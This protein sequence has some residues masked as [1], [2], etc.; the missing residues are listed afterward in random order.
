LV[1]LV[2]GSLHVLITTDTLSGVWSYTRELVTGLVAEGIRVTLV[3][4]GEI[5]V[6]SQTKWMENLKGLEYRPTAFGLDWMQEAEQ[7]YKDSCTYLAALVKERNPDL[8]HF[9]H[10][11]Y[12]SLNVKT[13]RVVVAHGDLINWWKAVHG[14]EPKETQWLRRYCQRIS[15]GLVEADAIVAPSVWMM[16]SLR[17]TYIVSRSI[18]SLS[19]RSAVAYHGRNPVMFNPYG[20]KDGSALALGRA[21]DPA[22]Q[23][24]LLTQHNHSVP[25]SIVASA[26]STPMPHLPIRTDVKFADEKT[27]IS[28]KGQQTEDQMRALYSRSS[29]Y[30]A[31]ARYDPFGTAG[32]EAAL[33]RCAILANDTPLFREMW[34]ESAVFF[35]TNSASSLA[36][37][38]RRLSEDRELRRSYANRAFH[39]AHECFTSKR[40]VDQYVAL[41]DG[42]LTG[43]QAKA[44]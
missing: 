21:F 27:A 36:S 15:E 20:K 37:E 17:D 24:G 19:K 39:R 10:P 25:I 28:M 12:G 18:S 33:S 23:L 11:C 30:V 42:V 5:P 13:H 6:P 31:T 22:S 1:L 9:N 2:E 34:G 4:F 8:L 16:D 3:S 14:R 44:A 35:R 7:D 43:F 41:Y 38:I 40:M 29:I 32:I 26:A